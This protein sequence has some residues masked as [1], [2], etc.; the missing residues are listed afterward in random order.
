MDRGNVQEASKTSSPRCT[1]ESAPVRYGTGPF[2]PTRQATLIED[3][4]LVSN[5][6]NTEEALPCGAVHLG[7][8]AALVSYKRDA[9]SAERRIVNSTYQSVIT[10]AKK[11]RKWITATVAS[12][13]GS[14]R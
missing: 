13:T 7:N 1:L 3:Q 14:L 5:S 9:C 6:V 10:K 8:R 12:I 11:P 4:P 2:N